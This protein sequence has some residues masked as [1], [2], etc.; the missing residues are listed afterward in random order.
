MQPDSPQTVCISRDELRVACRPRLFPESRTRTSTYAT[1]SMTERPS[2]YLNPDSAR[3]SAMALPGDRPNRR[4]FSPC[5]GTL[6]DSPCLPRT[7]IA[8][9]RPLLN[10]PESHAAILGFLL[11]LLESLGVSRVRQSAADLPNALVLLG[12]RTRPARGSTLAACPMATAFPSKPLP[13]AS[14]NYTPPAPANSTLAP[15]YPS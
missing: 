2:P 11:F 12:R 15:R 9:S 7:R 5:P 14:Q 4:L 8:Y 3:G 10:R 1:T 6:P 13:A